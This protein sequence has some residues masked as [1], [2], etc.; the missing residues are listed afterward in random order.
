MHA[1]E[2]IDGEIVILDQT[3]LPHEEVLRTLSSVGDIAEAIVSMRVRGAPALG[4]VGAMGVAQAALRPPT[5][6][7]KK[8]LERAADAARELAATRP[9]AV[10]LAWGIDRVLKHA[11]AI[12]LTAGPQ[13]LAAAM[14]AE[15]LAIQAEDE[16]ACD[17]MARNALDFFAPQGVVLTHCNTGMLCTGGVG[18][19][20]G[21]IRYAHDEGLGVAVVACE[22]RPLLQGARLTAWELQK[23]H[24]PHALIVDSAAAGLMAR[25]EISLVVVGADR[26]AAN[27]DVANKVGTYGHALAAKANGIPFIV[28][29]P[30]SSIDLSV[31]SGNKIDI[32]E[33]DA[34]EVTSV[35]GVALAPIGTNALNPAF[36]IT[37]ADL[38]T[39]IVTE[40][41]VARAPF[42][43]SL[44]EMLGAP[45]R[46]KA[47]R[48]APKA[49][50]E[51]APKTKPKPAPRAKAKPQPVSKTKPKVRVVS[52]K[53]KPLP[54]KT[55]KAPSR[56]KA[57]KKRAK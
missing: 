47:A 29:A 57:P 41:G 10:N 21:A 7:A 40:R 43:R 49:K 12:G 28:V 32:E 11:N 54:A 53:V 24:I 44:A 8:V 34:D 20:L 1:I 14:V 52:S 3:L 37:P 18:T 2:W 50:T 39:A 31:D 35:R 4:I 15:A 16:R 9:T 38:I 26:I 55:K 13:R 51:P 17:A 56:A 33:R 46:S 30:T 5:S 19:A 42:T 36:D 45:A 23:L 25:G 22:T 27:G 6:S 48:P